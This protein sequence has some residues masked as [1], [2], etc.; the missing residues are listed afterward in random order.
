MARLPSRPSCFSSFESLSASLAPLSQALRDILDLD[1]GDERIAVR[2]GVN[3]VLDDLRDRLHGLP[4][5]LASLTRSDREARRDLRG[6][7]FEYVSRDQYGFLLT[8]SEAVDCAPLLSQMRWMYTDG[9]RHHLKEART[10]QLD[11]EFGDLRSRIHDVETRFVAGLQEKVIQ[12][13]PHVLAAATRVYELDCHI[14]L[15]K[16]A[17]SLG[18]VRPELNDGD[19]LSITGGRHLLQAS[20]VAQ[21]IPN[22][23]ALGQRRSDGGGEVHVITGPNGSGL[24]SAAHHRSRRSLVHRP[25]ALTRLRCA[26][27]S[28]CTCSRW[29]SSRTW[30][31]AVRSCPRRPPASLCWTVSTRR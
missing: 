10:E 7:E 11:A 16:A 30:R 6:V 13:A 9:G 24:S 12:L 22:D 4:S 19:G 3:D 20:C 18:L 1:G 15:A 28:P 27:A 14:A 26:Q 17:T 29:V 2:L 23:T 8:I 25:H 5:F 21:F 31:C